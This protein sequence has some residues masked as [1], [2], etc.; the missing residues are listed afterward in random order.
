STHVLPVEEIDAQIEAVVSDFDVDEAKTGKGDGEGYGESK[1]PG[2]PG[3]GGCRDRKPRA[4]E[5]VRVPKSKYPIRA[6][7]RGLG[8]EA[9]AVL[10]VSAEGE[11][12][13]VEIVESAGHGFD[14]LAA[15]AFRKWTF[16]P[17]RRNCRA[18][19]DTVRVSH[20]FSVER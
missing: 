20:A 4:V 3:D 7:R 5:R 12:V 17:A 8:G 2:T 6:K 9:V 19:R 13:D 11:V 16:K 14:E 15:E 10:T 1:S 18:V